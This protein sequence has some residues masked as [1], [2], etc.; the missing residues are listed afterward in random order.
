MNRVAAFLLMAGALGAG[1]PDLPEPS[2]EE[3]R[4]AKRARNLRNKER[5][6]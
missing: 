5:G 4:A 1:L 6:A 3:R 2:A